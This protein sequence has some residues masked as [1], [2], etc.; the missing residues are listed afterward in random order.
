MPN[1]LIYMK[2][3]SFVMNFIDI[4][5]IFLLLIDIFDSIVLVYCA[6]KNIFY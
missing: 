1:Y 3:L 2:E 5:K 6:C 4:S